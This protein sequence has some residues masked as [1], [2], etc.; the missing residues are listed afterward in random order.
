MTF[1]DKAQIALQQSFKDYTIKDYIRLVI[2]IGAY[3][4]LRN[5]YTTWRTRLES[6][7]QEEREKIEREQS[8]TN[9]Y[10][11]ERAKLEDKSASSSASGAG[12]EK[13]Q[14]GQK[15]TQKAYQ[16]R[17]NFETQIRRQAEMMEEDESDKEID[18]F[19]MD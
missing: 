19:M 5:Q 18:E 12:G 7:K 14:W 10:E 1:L 17:K 2:I 15:A 13:F 3:V 8:A 16:R 6:K 9:K 4:L 11:E